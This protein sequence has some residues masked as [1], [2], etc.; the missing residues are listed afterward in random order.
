MKKNKR[1]TFSDAPSWYNNK[2]RAK[3]E[4]K[5]RTDAYAIREIN[6]NLYIDKEQE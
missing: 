5:K 2:R 1:N 6:N 3:H 4:S